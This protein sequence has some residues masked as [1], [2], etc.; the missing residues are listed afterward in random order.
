MLLI[1]WTYEVNLQKQKIKIISSIPHS[2]FTF[3]KASDEV[4]IVLIFSLKILKNILKNNVKQCSIFLI[5]FLKYWTL[6]ND[7]F[8]KYTS[9][10]NHY[11]LQNTYGYFEK[12][13][14]FLQN[15]K[16]WELAFFKIWC[17]LMQLSFKN[18]HT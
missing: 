2:T 10:K 18:L 8:S 13:M 12:Y 14:C 15:L 11:F 17:I 16:N 7:E 5:F 3:S 4:L 9:Y 6:C 1:G